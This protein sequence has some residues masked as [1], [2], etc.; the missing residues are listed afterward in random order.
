MHPSPFQSSGKSA[1]NQMSS[2]NLSVGR[3][4]LNSSDGGQLIQQPIDVATPFSNTSGNNISSIGGGGYASPDLQNSDFTD[5][6]FPSTLN[7]KA[8]SA[9]EQL[10]VKIGK[11]QQRIKLEQNA[12]EDNV[13][14]YLKLSTDAD[15]QQLQ[16]I[17]AVFE[18]KNIKSAQAIAHLQKKLE[19][20]DRKLREISL[21]GT[22]A[23]HKGSKGVLKDV[24]QGLRVLFVR[25]PTRSRDASPSTSTMQLK[26]RNAATLP[27]VWKT[28]DSH[29]AFKNRYGSA[30]NITSSLIPTQSSVNPSNPNNLQSSSSANNS[31]IVNLTSQQQRLQLQQ[32]LQQ[33]QHQQL[34]DDSLNDEQQ[35]Q[36]LAIMQA[37]DLATIITN[38]TE[39]QEMQY[40]LHCSVSTLKTQLDEEGIFCRQALEE[41]HDRCE[42]LE[43]QINDLT[44]LHQ[45]EM[46]NIKQEMVGMQEKMEYQ[47]EERTRDIQELLLTCQTRINKMELQQQQQQLISMEGIEN[48]SFRG[49]ATKLINIVL[50]VLAVVLVLVSEVANLIGPFLQTRLRIVGTALLASL[51]AILW[52]RRLDLSDLLDRFSL[53]GNGTLSSSSF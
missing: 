48:T 28:K 4:S 20:Y 44:E 42:R 6:S 39:F 43:E 38:L 7:S 37:K 18:K 29:H 32:R 21:Q 45:N 5:G 14:E 25:D 1:G 11:T 36:Q 26:S 13:N 41:E 22:T 16:R 8:R 19:E 24:G 50:A 47:L 52:N 15:K 30:D 9:I 2:S 10:Q 17:K 23:I 3:E 51:L 12:K 34:Q 35:Q 46:Y 33:Q 27:G 49:L 40:K 31:P 53:F